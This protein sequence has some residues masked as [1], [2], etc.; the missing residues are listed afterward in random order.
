MATCV[1]ISIQITRAQ[2]YYKSIEARLKQKH[3]KM[4]ILSKKMPENLNLKKAR[5][6]KQSAI[7]KSLYSEIK[8]L[9]LLKSEAIARVLTLADKELK[10]IDKQIEVRE[11]YLTTNNISPKFALDFLEK[12]EISSVKEMER[13]DEVPAICQNNRKAL[14]GKKGVD[15]TSCEDSL[16][17]SSE[18]YAYSSASHLR[19]PSRMDTLSIFEASPM[20]KRVKIS[21]EEEKQTPGGGE[22]SI[23]ESA[24]SKQNISAPVRKSKRK[25]KKSKILREA[26]GEF[27]EEPTLPII[28]N[29]KKNKESREANIMIELDSIAKKREEL[30]PVIKN[31]QFMVE[32][33][34]PL[35]SPD[36]EV[37]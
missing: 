9:S 5:D 31:D 7:L 13:S 16:M 37:V 33:D 1:P 4:I 12:R 26:M 21:E 27:D 30:I 10:K 18:T 35:L 36:A 32:Y 20:M 17:A 22:F 29:S 11:S 15:S 28:K 3:R 19:S 34:F 6:R 2:E 25:V 24:I 14:K 8:D 23:G